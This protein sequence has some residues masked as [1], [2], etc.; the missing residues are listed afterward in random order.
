[1]N[2]QELDNFR[3]KN[4]YDYYYDNIYTDKEKLLLKQQMEI[5]L[6]SRIVLTREDKIDIKKD[7]TIYL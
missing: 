3:F 6:N 1:M 7:F 4:G 2:R 5:R